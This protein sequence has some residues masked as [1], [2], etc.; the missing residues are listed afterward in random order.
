MKIKKLI[1]A[2]RGKQ[3]MLDSELVAL[4]QLE[5]KNLNKAVKR[6]LDRFPEKFCFQITD[7]ES[8]F[9]RFQF[10]TSNVG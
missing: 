7:E 5:T 8:E 6:N 3:V 2:I 9:L 1:Y 4:Y 10:G